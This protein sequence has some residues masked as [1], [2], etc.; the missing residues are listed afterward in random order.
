MDLLFG[1]DRFQCQ[2][3]VPAVFRGPERPAVKRCRFAALIVFHV[4]LAKLAMRQVRLK[5]INSNSKQI[6]RKM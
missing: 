5:C 1:P 2:F 3:V 4:T 6:D